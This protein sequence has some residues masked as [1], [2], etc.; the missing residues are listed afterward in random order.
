MI[1]W[2]NLPT[3]RTSVGA[4]TMKETIR[5]LTKALRQS[6]RAFECLNQFEISV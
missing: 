5:N 4:M 1:G 2:R 6:N 3:S